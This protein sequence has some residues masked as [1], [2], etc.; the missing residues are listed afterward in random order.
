MQGGQLWNGFDEAN[1]RWQAGQSNDSRSPDASIYGATFMPANGRRATVIA[2]RILDGRLR[3][4]DDRKPFSHA[5]RSVVRAWLPSGSSWDGPNPRSHQ[6]P[7]QHARGPHVW[8]SPRKSRPFARGVWRRRP[9]QLVFASRSWRFP[10]EPTASR[11]PARRALLCMSSD[12][13]R[14]GLEQGGAP[15]RGGHRVARASS[16]S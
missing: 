10:L 3:S 5:C 1:R 2:R 16:A 15:G 4:G 14:V 6:V 11:F 8:D 9:H 7:L 12:H 13:R